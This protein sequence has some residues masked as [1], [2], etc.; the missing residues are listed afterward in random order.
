MSVWL[1]GGLVVWGLEVSA[2][3]HALSHP[4]AHPLVFGSKNIWSHVTTLPE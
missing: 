4:K 2:R 3:G 1:V